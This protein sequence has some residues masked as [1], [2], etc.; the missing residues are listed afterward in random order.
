MNNVI[1]IWTRVT[2]LD[3]KKRVLAVVLSFEGR[4]RDTELEISLEDLNKDDGV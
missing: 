3:D 2:N 4:A 1:G